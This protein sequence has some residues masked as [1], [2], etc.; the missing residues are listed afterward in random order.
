MQVACES[1]DPDA[2]LQKWDSGFITMGS[3][4]FAFGGTEDR[5]ISRGLGQGGSTDWAY[6][7]T[8]CMPTAQPVPTA[9]SR[10]SRQH[11]MSVS[12]PKWTGVKD[13]HFAFASSDV[14]DSFMRALQAAVARAAADDNARAA[15]VFIRGVRGSGSSGNGL[16]RPTSEMHEYRVLYVK[17]G[18]DNWWLEHF[19]GKWMLKQK[20]HKGTSLSW[21]VVAGG[22]ALEDCG[23]RV[24]E[25]A[26]DKSSPSFVEDRNIRIAFGGEALV[27]AEAKS[28]M[29]R[30]S[31]C[32]HHLL[33]NVCTVCRSRA[34]ATIP[35]RYS[36]N[37]T[38]GLSRWAAACLRLAAPK[39]KP[40]TEAS[41]YRVVQLKHTRPCP[42]QAACLLQLHVIQGSTLCLYHSPNG[43]VSKISTLHLHLQMYA[44]HS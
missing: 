9:A 29:V 14:R 27:A 26:F 20:E 36:R 11:V 17:E 28:T 8:G 24:W 15:A 40:S 4:L 42:S 10:D 32:V 34:S 30:F 25:F 7:I 21:A 12:F 35:M 19:G 18:D 16:Y 13:Q 31:I 39:T 37:G 41:G 22:C 43:L 3:S 2:L 6:P 44:T 33:C 1:Y 38:A 5:A 23:S